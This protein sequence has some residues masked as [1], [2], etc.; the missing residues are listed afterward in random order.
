VLGFFFG[1]EVRHE[2][3]PK[4]ERIA[5]SARFFEREAFHVVGFLQVQVNGF[6][7]VKI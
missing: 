3:L 4:G 6:G 2:L 7:F 5:Q 1:V